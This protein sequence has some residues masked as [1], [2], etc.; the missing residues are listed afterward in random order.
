MSDLMIS[1]SKIII[2][3]KVIKFITSDKIYD[4]VICNIINKTHEILKRFV[5]TYSFVT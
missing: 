2:C 4:E 5:Y 3:V 1:V